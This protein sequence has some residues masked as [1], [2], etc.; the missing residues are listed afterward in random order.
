MPRHKNRVIVD[1]DT[2]NKSISTAA[3]NPRQFRSSTLK[4]R[5]LGLPTLKCFSSLHYNQV[6]F[7]RP[8]WNQMNFD[9]PRKK[10]VDFHAYTK[11]KGF[12]A[13]TQY[14]SQFPIGPSHKKSVNFETHTKTE[15]I[16]TSALKP[17]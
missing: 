7:D 3:Q 5:Q 11:T 9:H 14:P 17:S 13:R 10:Q 12:A 15:S 16:L 4:L 8:H 1:E 2:Q 6:K